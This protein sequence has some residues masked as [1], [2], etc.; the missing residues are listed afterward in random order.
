MVIKPILLVLDI[1]VLDG[2]QNIEIFHT[3]FTINFDVIGNKMVF[4][5]FVFASFKHK[6]RANCGT[7]LELYPLIFILFIYQ[8]SFNQL[9]LKNNK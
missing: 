2:N 3:Y 6:K 8:S 7:F 9:C 1:D 4:S 5:I